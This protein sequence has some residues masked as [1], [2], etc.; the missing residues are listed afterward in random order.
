MSIRFYK[1][2]AIGVLRKNIYA[3][4]PFFNK[5]ALPEGII[6]VIRKRKTQKTF[7]HEKNAVYTTVL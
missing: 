7:P 3:S 1:Y 5:K 6:Y 2:L 4:I